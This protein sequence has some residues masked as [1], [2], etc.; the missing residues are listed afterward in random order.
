[1]AS[2][3]DNSTPLD[4]NG[5]PLNLN[6]G[7]ARLNDRVIDELIGLCKG[8]IADGVVTQGEAEFLYQWLQDNRRVADGFPA[9]MVYRRVSEFLADGVLD[10]EESAELFTLLQELTGGGH[11]A[12]APSLSGS[13]PLCHPVP[14]IDFVGRSFC[15]TG[16][17]V[18]GKRTKMQMFV[19][20][21]GGKAV[22]NP[23]SKTDYVVI[24]EVGS[25]DW[26]H[27]THGRKIEKA[28]ELRDS[29]AKLAIVSEEHWIACVAAAAEALEA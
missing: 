28:V 13:L 3:S 2:D 19:E 8:V 4:A 5:Q 1:M 16:Q 7:S 24:G 18:T 15:L 11:K 6:F 12:G 20:A 26:I 29:G 25:R 17:F 14:D 27:S 23:S 21:L 9:N 22:S 10:A